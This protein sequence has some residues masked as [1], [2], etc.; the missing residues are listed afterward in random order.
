VPSWPW[1]EL[2]N[3]AAKDMFAKR[4]M[5]AAPGVEDCKHGVEDAHAYLAE[6]CAAR[7]HARQ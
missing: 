6:Q 5:P 3:A 2:W 4:R 1:R 7:R